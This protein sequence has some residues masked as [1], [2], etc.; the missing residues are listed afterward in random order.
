[1]H[2][3][4]RFQGSFAPR[5]C[6][7]GLAL[8]GPERNAIRNGTDPPRIV[9]TAA[10]PVPGQRLTLAAALHKF[11]TT[12]SCFQIFVAVTVGNY[13]L[14]SVCIG[15]LVLWGRRWH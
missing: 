12:K 2:R 6:V 5:A 3:L 9:L 11:A 8:P 13:T 15:D 4:Q 7:L 1:M 10:V 14:R